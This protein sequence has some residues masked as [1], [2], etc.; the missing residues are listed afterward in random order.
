MSKRDRDRHSLLFLELLT[1]PKSSA[2]ERRLRMNQNN[3]ILFGKNSV[4]KTI[5]VK[6]YSF[7]TRVEDL[8]HVYFVIL[9]GILGM[10]EFFIVSK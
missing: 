1:K 2:V 10:P 8:S 3:D 4:D 5:L 9:G 6:N 7:S